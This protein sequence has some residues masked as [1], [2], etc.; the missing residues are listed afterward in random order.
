MASAPGEP[1]EKPIRYRQGSNWRMI[2]GL[3][4]WGISY[5][6]LEDYEHRMPELERQLLRDLGSAFQRATERRRRPFR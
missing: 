1:W 2:S 3:D 6:A 4:V 5:K